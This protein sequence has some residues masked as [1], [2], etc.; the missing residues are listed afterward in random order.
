VSLVMGM[1]QHGQISAEWIDT[2]TA[3]V[4]RAQIAPADSAGVRKFLER[5]AGEDLEVALEA[6]TGWRFGVEELERVGAEVHRRADRDR[7]VEE[8]LGSAWAG[9]VASCPLA[10]ADGVSA[11]TSSRPSATT[12]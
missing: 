5:F 12:R 4:F 6:A 8:Q 7:R 11:T 1:D 2:M 9:A 3:E 10:P